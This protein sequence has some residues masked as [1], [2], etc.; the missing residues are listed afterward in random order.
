M[1]KQIKPYGGFGTFKGV[2]FS[3]NGIF[4]KEG[5]EVIIS[6]VLGLRLGLGSELVTS[7]SRVYIKK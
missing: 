4:Y 3:D 7:E 6:M 5:C 1:N 2:F